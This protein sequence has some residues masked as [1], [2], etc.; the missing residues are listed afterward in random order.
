MTDTPT[1]SYAVAPEALKHALAE[2][3]G[4]RVCRWTSCAKS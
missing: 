1:T 4:E 3:L 2:L